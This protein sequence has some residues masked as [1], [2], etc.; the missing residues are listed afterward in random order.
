MSPTTWNLL[1]LYL[2][3]DPAAIPLF[4]ADAQYASVVG[5]PAHDYGEW[6]SSVGEAQP[7]VYRNCA[8]ATTTSTALL[9]PGTRSLCQPAQPGIRGTGIHSDSL[10]DRRLRAS[11][12]GDLTS[13]GP[14]SYLTAALYTYRGFNTEELVVRDLTKYY[15]GTTTPENLPPTAPAD[16]Q[17]SYGADEATTTVTVSWLPSTD[18]DS[19][20][21]G[22]L[23]EWRATV[24][25]STLPDHWQAVELWGGPGS[26]VRRMMRVPRALG[27]AHVFEIRAKDDQGAASAAGGAT[28]FL[29]PLETCA[30]RAARNPYFAID[31]VMR[32]GNEIKIR[33]RLLQNPGEGSVWALFPYLSA[34]ESAPSTNRALH[35]APNGN[36][37]YPKT[38]F[39]T[40]AQC[41]EAITHL[42]EYRIGRQYL[43]K[44]TEL[45]GRAAQTIVP[46]A[47]VAFSMF[48]G[49]PC[50]INAAADTP[51][52]SDTAEYAAE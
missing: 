38:T 15:F 40:T 33:W 14:G 2:N 41:N 9:I 49:S 12:S 25:S 18:L 43:T 22:I 39:K 52:Y 21:A 17:F 6:G 34:R 44:F 31:C 10:E 42:D 13:L 36:P 50:A 23:Y 45:S 1:V 4:Y 3:R 20:D 51:F 24:G 28:L 7:F 46:G 37:D 47:I 16:I 8:N 29:P 27:Q 30:E 11:L 35:R 19:L 26:D 48:R 32:A 5:S